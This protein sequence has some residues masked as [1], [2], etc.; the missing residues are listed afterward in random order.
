MHEIGYDINPAKKNSKNYSI[1]IKAFQMH[2]LRGNITGKVNTLTYQK[3][4]SY[5][6]ELLT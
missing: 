1:L 4:L 5:F 6:N 3:I 2:Y